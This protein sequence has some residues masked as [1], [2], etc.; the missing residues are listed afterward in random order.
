VNTLA[1]NGPVL[2]PSKPT[3]IVF[4]SR[5]A[6]MLARHG[7]HSGELTIGDPVGFVTP[8]SGSIVTINRCIPAAIRNA[9]T[10]FGSGPRTPSDTTE[11][12]TTVQS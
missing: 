6:P 3:L 9:E 10:T 8:P 11:P 2:N 1:P 4:L 7:R 12:R 5:W